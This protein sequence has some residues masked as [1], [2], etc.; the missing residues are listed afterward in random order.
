M[1][2]K[3]QVSHCGLKNGQTV[4]L[5]PDEK[6]GFVCEECR[7]LFEVDYNGNIT[8][9]PLLRAD[10]VYADNRIREISKYRRIHN[11]LDTN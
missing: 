6:I 7:K 8:Q 4:E 5:K 3:I 10:V 11:R 1:T 9:S 2:K